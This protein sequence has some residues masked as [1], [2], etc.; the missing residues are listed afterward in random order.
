MH[1]RTLLLGTLLL[2]QGCSYAISPQTAAQAD[3]TIPFAKLSADPTDYAGKL[4]ILGG[5]IVETRTMKSGSVIEVRQKELDYWGRPRRTKRSGGVFI[6]L[7]R[8]QLDPMVYAA[9]REVTVA[10][11]VAGAGERGAG[12]DLAG[13]L[14]L[15]SKELKLWPL[16]RLTSDK[17]QWLDPLYDPRSPKASQGY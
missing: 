3:R 14:V 1:I 11:E 4:V 13:H 17:P 8:A 2:M 16:E 15:Q 10:G 5:E 7:H 6:V 12:P 9:G